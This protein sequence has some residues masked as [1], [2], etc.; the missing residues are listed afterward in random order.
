[1]IHN[2][3][4]YKEGLNVDTVPFNPS[5]DCEPGGLYYTNEEHIFTFLEFGSLIADV[6]VPEDAKVYKNGNKY[7]ADKI[8]LSNVRRV[9][10]YINSFTYEEKLRIV[11][12]QLLL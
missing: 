12:F 6:I 10:D 8:I 5:G 7:K 3:F 2:G 11:G 9:E 4:Q 1:M